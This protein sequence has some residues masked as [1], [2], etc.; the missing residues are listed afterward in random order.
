MKKH[1]SLLIALAC[2]ALTTNVTAQAVKYV[3]FEHFTQASCGPC[4]QQNPSFQNDIL[5]N[6]KGVV[7]HIAYHTSWPGTDPMNAYNPT[8]VQD[9][10]T[11]YNVSGV[12]TMQMLGKYWTGQPGGVTQSMVNSE[13]SKGSPISIR[14]T[15]T[16]DGSIRTVRVVVHSFGTP[17]T[18]T[19]FLRTVVIESDISYTSPP[20]SN[21]E[22]DF[23]N[24]MRKMLPNPSGYSYTAAPQ[25]D[26]VVFISA[27]S[28][29]QAN[30]DTTKIYVVAFVQDDVTG[31]VI[32][33]GS[34]TDPK[35]SML[36]DGSDFQLAS[37]S[38]N[39]SFTATITNN[40]TVSGNF[41]L[42]F[43]SDH[44]ADWTATNMYNSTAVGDDSGDSIDITLAAGANAV[45]GIDALPGQL[46][47]IGNYSVSM[48]SLDD[49]SIS[50]KIVEFHLIYNVRD[51]VVSNAS[52]V[53]DGSGAN[54][55]N[56][57]SD[58]VDGLVYAGNTLHGKTTHTVL[59]KGFEENALTDVK[60]IYYNVGWT[61]PSF[62]DD[63]VQYLSTFLDN[64]GRLL[65][66]GQDVG[67]DIWEG[68]GTPAQQSFYTNYL[69][70]NYL[71]DL[72]PAPND[73]MSFNSADSV[74][75]N[76]SSSEIINYY[77]GTYF[78]PELISPRTGADA[79]YF[80]NGDTSKVG[81]VRYSNGTFKTVY[82]GV[83]LEM[84]GD[85]TVSNE[86]MKLA[87]DWFWDGITLTGVTEPIASEKGSMNI[88]P[89]PFSEQSEL[90]F[91]LTHASKVSLSV[92]SLTGQVLYSENMGVLAEGNHQTILSAATLN[93]GIYFVKLNAGENSSTQ[94]IIIND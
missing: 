16:S 31:E 12:P 82:L 60:N 32:N 39:K 29:D 42:K 90:H 83:G 11:Y 53:G 35:W 72:A 64:G 4:A 18:G 14:V 19:M 21:G 3:L 85:T 36:S 71:N 49:T 5:Q 25:G 74:F 48:Q 33:S 93:A 34:S 15:E 17:P 6:N 61:F 23:P 44:P 84:L 37:P 51:L 66:A 92:Y 27:Y 52:G 9:R 47:G 57:E 65:V 26:S 68:N 78:F 91:V 86:I 41:R 8:D 1:Y 7:H 88:F 81:G 54:A 46:S 79:I 69:G 73:T 24:V 38:S 76:V 13:A 89:N 22:K 20:G 55:T 28:L 94:K 63:L 75:G 45:V 56:W 87:H 10:V 40:N 43:T 67:W 58:Y 80:Y 70:A 30:W 50:A 62:S 77:G 2:S 59:M